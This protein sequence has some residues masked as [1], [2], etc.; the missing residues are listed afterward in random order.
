MSEM[1]IPLKLKYR[2][3]AQRLLRRDGVDPPGGTLVYN[4]GRYQSKSS[5]SGGNQ[6]VSIES[7]L[8]PRRRVY[9]GFLCPA[10]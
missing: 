6:R 2:N 8:R 5:N 10:G 1:L 9:G 4:A 3:P 7:Y